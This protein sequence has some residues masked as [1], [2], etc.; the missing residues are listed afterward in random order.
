[1]QKSYSIAT[2]L[3]LTQ[4]LRSFLLILALGG[5]T[6]ASAFAVFASDISNLQELATGFHEPLVPTAATSKDEDQALIRAV[7]SYREGHDFRA[8]EIFL[9]EHPVS[10]W[11]VAILTNLALTSYYSGHFSKA[12]SYFE[13][14]WRE[15]RAAT[16]PRAKVLVDRAVGELL[17]MH[18]RLG[19]REELSNLFEDIGE[20]A[21]VGPATEL[22]T[23]AKEGLWTMHH[24]PGVAYLCGPI[25]LKNLLRATGGP[26]GDRA[27]LDHYRSSPE[28]VSLAEVAGLAEQAKFAYRLVHREAGAPIPVPSIVHWKVNHFAAIVSEQSGRFKIQDPTFGEDLWL[29]RDAIES[30]SSGYFLVL[31]GNRNEAWREIDADEAGRI[32]GKGVTSTN[33]PTATTPQD[34]KAKP[35]NCNRAMCGYNFTEMVVSL[36]LT[37]TP[38]GY[39]PP[40]G[41]P[42]Y[43]TLTYNQREASQPANLSFFNVSPKWSLNWLTYI[44]DDPHPSAAGVNVTRYVAGGGSIR[45]SGYDLNTRAFSPEARDASILVRSQQPSGRVFYQRKLADGGEELYNQPDDAT[46]FPRRIFLTRITD[47]AGK[48]ITLNYDSSRRLTS[49]T[50][51]TNRITTISYGVPGRPLLISQITDPFG[52]RARLLYDSNG[53]LIEITDVL[54]FKSRFKHDGSSLINGMTTPYGTTRFEYGESGGNLGIFR[55]IEATDPLGNAERL[56]FRQFAAAQG[57]PG[58]PH[59]DPVDTVPQGITAPFNRY[60]DAR[61][62]FYWDKHAHKVA[63]GDYTQARIKHWAHL[64]GTNTTQTAN[65]VESIKYPLENRI[66]FNYPGQPNDGLGATL[67]GTLYKPTKIGRVLDDGSTQLIQLQYNAAG[68]PTSVIDPVGRET[69]FTYAD[70]QIDLLTVSQKVGSD[71]SVIGQYEYGTGH[72]L[73]TYTDAAGQTTSFTYNNAGQ[74]VKTENVLGETMATYDYDSLGDLRLILNFNGDRQAILDYDTFGRLERYFDL[75]HIASNDSGVWKIQYTYDAMDRLTSETYSDGSRRSYT[76]DKLDLVKVSDRKGRTTA[77]TYDSVRNLTAVTDPLGN[78][79]KFGYYENQKLKSLTD[80]RGNTTT[81]GID[82]QSRVTA[83]AYP[84]GSAVSYTYEATTSR[85][86]AVRDALGQEKQ[87]SYAP[88]NRPTGTTYLNAVHPTPNTQLTYDAFFPRIVSM[89]DGSGKTEYQYGPVGSLGAL[90]LSKELGPFQNATIAYHYDLLGRVVARIV[91]GNTETYSYDPIG[92]LVGHTNNLGS[93][94]IAYL[95]QTTRPV[96]RGNATVGT[97]WAYESNLGDR[98]LNSIA[99]RETARSYQYMSFPELGISKI[100]ETRTDATTQEWGYGYDATD[101]LLSAQAAPGGAYGYAYDPADNITAIQRPDGSSALTY[102]NLNQINTFDEVLFSYDANGN[103]IADDR[104]TYTWDAEN[105]M[106][107]IGYKNQPSKQTSFRY[108]GLGR[109]V[110]IVSRD[111]ST[112]RETRYLWCGN[113][114]CQARDATD[115]V[116]RRYFTEGEEIP[117]AG[118]LLYY[119]RDHLGSVRDLLSAQSGTQ[120]ASFDY[121]PYG[122]VLHASGQVTSDRR[123]AGMFYEQ[124]SGLYL[125]HYR[126]YDP[127]T[128]RWLSRDPIGEFGA[129]NIRSVKMIYGARDYDAQTGRW[130]AKD[131]IWFRGR[132]ANLY[133]YTRADPVN[134]TDP[135]G[136][137]PPSGGVN[138]AAVCPLTEPDSCES[139]GPQWARDMWLGEFLFHYNNTCYREDRLAS[140]YSTAQC[141]YEGGTLV[142]EGRWY[143]GSADEFDPYFEPWNHFCNDAGGIC[144]WV[145]EGGYFGGT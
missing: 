111:G 9:S 39:R 25:A 11:R 98:R 82:V 59:S 134:H 75:R 67:S 119:A 140:G 77:Y 83:K 30:E 74:M 55:F 117:G 107:S 43:T 33:Q 10:G 34:D 115:T 3:L 51:A 28:G 141:C 66:W 86:K 27:F 56:E 36:N 95:G 69:L 133:G 54:G 137:M 5:T 68:K 110:A 52:R 78:T 118:T 37:D 47:S 50:D 71:Y 99:N 61:N 20:R 49:I 114:L 63:P 64:A 139:T 44:E 105:R 4:P 136:L 88:D 8:L 112:D 81:W 123:Y 24:E 94:A 42:V 113:S 73:R 41:P 92:R 100:T 70:N 87:F 103:L 97:T 40:I 31:E 109:R 130:T 131:P 22:R 128:G 104:H 143:S 16:E 106:V 126:A 14:A 38:V 7:K 48:F 19:H 122:G 96:S 84:D 102:N 65:T 29:T 53:R 15:G 13:E 135:T 58:I 89:T 79:T 125:T 76:W 101:R 145:K 72:R 32:R 2:S 132:D 80:P 57:P 121:D 144:A 60:L 46:T 17:R 138:G 90:Q 85:L 1:M 45:Y 12:I 93:F 129:T 23:G 21:L 18:A 124:D 142:P 116:I 35:S 6:P 108:D 26:A 91:G 127:R 62:T 120:V